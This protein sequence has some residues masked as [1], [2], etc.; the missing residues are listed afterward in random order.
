MKILEFPNALSSFP[1]MLESGERIN[2][3]AYRKESPRNSTRACSGQS[4]LTATGAAG[5]GSGGTRL[6]ETSRS[7]EVIWFSTS[8][9]CRTDHCPTKGRKKR[10]TKG[11][12]E[13]EEGISAMDERH[14]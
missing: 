3:S 5:C 14:G 11:K 13:P 2:F 6:Y 4:G 7:T 1:V 9:L 12:K 10:R 8:A